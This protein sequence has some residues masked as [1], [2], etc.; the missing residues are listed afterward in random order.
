MTP[1]ERWDS[2]STFERGDAIARDYADAIRAA[3]DEERLR[4][5]KIA[6]EVYGV[7]TAIGNAI[8][9]TDPV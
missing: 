9:K 1:L 6:W 7:G 5:A 4:C 3:V 8:M 2:C